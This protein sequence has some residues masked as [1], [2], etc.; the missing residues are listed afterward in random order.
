M[1]SV[2]VTTIDFILH[3]LS[4]TSNNH[5]ILRLLIIRALLSNKIVHILEHL[6]HTEVIA[7]LLT[8]H[9]IITYFLFVYQIDTPLSGFQCAD[10]KEY[11]KQ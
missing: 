9:V 4:V 5:L 2:I 10:S 6:V 1:G 7:R 3:I 11:E 8:E